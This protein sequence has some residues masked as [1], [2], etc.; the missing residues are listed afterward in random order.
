MGGEENA[1]AITSECVVT[2]SC[3]N[4]GS[5]PGGGGSGDGDFSLPFSYYYVASAVVAGIVILAMLVMCCLRSL[6]SFPPSFLVCLALLMR[7]VPVEPVPA[8]G[9]TSKL[10]PPELQRN[11]TVSKQCP[12]SS[13]SLA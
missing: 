6:A 11:D 12:C 10:S 9:I 4:G 3:P 7:Y 1:T 5:V 2:G 13:S 8:S